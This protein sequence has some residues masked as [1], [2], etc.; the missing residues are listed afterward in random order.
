MPS[1]NATYDL[2]VIGAGPGGYTAAIHASRAGWRC[3]LVEAQQN[4]GGVCLNWGCIPTKSLLRAAEV[5]GLVRNAG[6]FGVQVKGV[7]VHWDRVMARSRQ[8]PRELAAGVAGLMDKHGVTV[9][10]GRGRIT[11]TRQVQVCGTRGGVET[12]LSTT[13]VLLAAGG[14]PRSLPGVEI[15]GERVWSSR[16]ALEAASCPDSLAIVGA[17][18]VGVEFAC[19][20]AAFGCRVTLVEAAAQVLPHEET[21]IARVLESALAAQGIEVK[22]GAE[23]AGVV[24]DDTSGVRLD[25]RRGSGAPADRVEAE[26]ALLAVGVTGNT[27]G[28]GLEAVGIRTRNGVVAVD[29]RF[30]TS[31]RGV[32][33][34]GDLIGSPQLA[35]AAAAEA[36]LAV[37]A[38]GGR[39]ARSLA[40][41]QVPRCVYSRPQV[42]SVG[43]TEADARQRHGEVRVGRFPFAANGLARATGETEGLVKLVFGARYGELLGAAIVG[44]E[45]TELIAELG[46]AIALEA[47]YEE[48]ADTVHAHPTLS[49]AV[50]EA[51]GAAFGR[52]VNI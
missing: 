46:L 4:L 13:H 20:F 15:D 29:D 21:Q 35:H 30:E 14:S 18:P 47:T 50:M 10:C 52:A 51:A 34:V 23:V 49:E 27:D 24:V 32:Y 16:H 43:L 1:E 26:R 40:R 22:V 12:T 6:D 37:E 44:P 42:A 2:V 39:P 45:A 19:F 11:P 31:A 7:H 36:R 28:L 41:A 38:M 8:V 17:G 5:Y 48:L 3:A 33:A 25:L 9:L